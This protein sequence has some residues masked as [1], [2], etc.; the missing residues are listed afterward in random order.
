M[1]RKCPRPFFETPRKRTAPDQDDANNS[2]IRIDVDGFPQQPRQ[3][4]PMA[5][6]TAISSGV[7]LSMASG[8]EEGPADV[9][10]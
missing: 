1:G 4:F 10:C 8:T 5:R 7:G 6:S 9:G 2:L 3:I